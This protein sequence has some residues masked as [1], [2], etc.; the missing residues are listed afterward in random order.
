MDKKELISLL[1]ELA[2][3]DLAD[4]ADLSD[5]PC[6]V[7]V[8]ALEQCFD[9]LHYMKQMAKGVHNKQCKRARML[10]LTTYNPSW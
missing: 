6:S 9:D 3:D 4:G 1:E 10:I 7:A 2:I 8:R 5:H